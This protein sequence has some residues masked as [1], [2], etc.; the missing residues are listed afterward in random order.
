LNR[1][2]KNLEQ[3]NNSLKFMLATR[4]PMV[5]SEINS[6]I[7]SPDTINPVY[8]ATPSGQ[9]IERINEKAYGRNLNDKYDL[10]FSEPVNKYAFD[11]S[12]MDM[13]ENEQHEFTPDP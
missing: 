3:E 4:Q 8:N 10:N 2:V 1:K 11:I 6:P 12:P 13:V 7:M 5:P 9:V